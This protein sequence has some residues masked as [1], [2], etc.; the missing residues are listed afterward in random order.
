MILTFVPP[1][2]VSAKLWVPGGLPV[3]D[4]HIT[5]LHFESAESFDV[6]SRIIEVATRYA[7]EASR[8]NAKVT[9]LS[10]FENVRKMQNEMGEIVD[11]TEPTDVVLASLDTLGIAAERE[12]LR[13][14]CDELGAP[15]STTFSQFLPHMSIKYVPHGSPLDKHISFPI[16][17][18][19]DNVQVW[20]KEGERLTFHFQK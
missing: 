16:T 7:Q 19:I 17:F 4:M 10:R 8:F 11:A 6:G 15:Y 13:S 14:L 12:K 1:S 18:T 3:S 9:S 20:P 2:E 5:L